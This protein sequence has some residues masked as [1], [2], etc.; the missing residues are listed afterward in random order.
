MSSCNP[1]VALLAKKGE[2][3]IRITAKFAQEM[4]ERQ[5]QKMENIIR[6]RLGDHMLMMK[7][8]RVW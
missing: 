6:E 1:T 2:V 7:L 8:W 4:A 5:I 3:H